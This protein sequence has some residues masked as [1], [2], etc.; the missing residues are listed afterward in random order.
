MN[1]PFIPNG[2]IK[3]GDISG[4][5]FCNFIVSTYEADVHWRPYVL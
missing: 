1:S 2:D 4:E 5:Q 3:W